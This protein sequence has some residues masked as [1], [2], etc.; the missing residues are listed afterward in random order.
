MQ[1]NYM[2]S[3]TRREI[4]EEMLILCEARQREFSEGFRMIIPARGYE[5]AYERER[6]KAEIIREMLR[7]LM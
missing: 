6:K 1:S 3:V 2:P 4:L 7:E 5:V